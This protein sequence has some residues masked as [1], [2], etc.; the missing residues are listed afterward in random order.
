MEQLVQAMDHPLVPIL[1]LG[2]VLQVELVQAVAPLAR[3]LALVAELS[4][5]LCSTVCDVVQTSAM[6]YTCTIYCCLEV[7]DV[8]W[9]QP[10]F[11]ALLCRE[12]LL[13]Q[14]DGFLLVLEQFFPILCTET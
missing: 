5:R 7:A 11:A 12:L 2:M 8:G 3:A 9:L 13:Q 6:V 4:H 14:S 1:A 10:N